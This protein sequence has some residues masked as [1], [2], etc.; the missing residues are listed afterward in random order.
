MN[1]YKPNWT[2]I[3]DI[4]AIFINEILDDATETFQKHAFLTVEFVTPYKTDPSI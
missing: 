4:D 2:K 3:T 1:L